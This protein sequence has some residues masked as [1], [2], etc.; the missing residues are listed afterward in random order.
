ML[1]ALLE[2]IG[3]FVYG[4]SEAA[5]VSRRVARLVAAVLVFLGLL[6]IAWAISLLF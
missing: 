6:A 4:T 3:Y 2:F 1:A 5:G